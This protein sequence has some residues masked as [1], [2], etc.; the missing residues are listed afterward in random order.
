MT[1][2][3]AYTIA[4]SFTALPCTVCTVAWAFIRDLLTISCAGHAFAAIIV[5]GLAVVSI[6]STK[7]NDPALTQVTNVLLCVFIGAN[8]L[9]QV[10]PY[11]PL[12]RSSADSAQFETLNKV[13]RLL[14]LLP[15]Y[16]LICIVFA[17][18]ITGL[19]I[20]AVIILV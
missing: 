17:R 12:R 10:T 19:E 9:V 16:A 6:S 13:L 15:Q 20:V 4:L 7:L 18:V 2:L 5:A 1:V 11:S 3:H 14:D 8:P